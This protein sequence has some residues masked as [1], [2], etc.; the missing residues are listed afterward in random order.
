[1][2]PLEWARSL[3]EVEQTACHIEHGGSR[4]VAEAFFET[5]LDSSK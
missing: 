2:T 3:L 1:M 4:K 5:A